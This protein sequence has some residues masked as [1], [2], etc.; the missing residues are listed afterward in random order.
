MDLLTDLLRQCG[1]HRRLLD[2]RQLAPGR[3]LA[4]PCERSIGLHVVTRGRVYVHA[5]GLP[6][7]LELHAGDA[8]VMAR[9]CHHR[10][11]TQ[12]QIDGLPVQTI[13]VDEGAPPEAGAAAGDTTVISGAYQLWHAPVHRLLNELPPWFVVR[14]DSLP[15][16]SPLP[17][18]IGLLEGEAPRREPGAEMVVNG[19]LDA[20]FAWL[21]REWMAR[22]GA[23]RAG[24]ALAVRDPAVREAVRHLHEAPARPWT[25]ESLAQAVGLSRS[26]LAERFRT[27]MGDTPLA[28]LRTLR[29][30][31]AMRLLAESDLTLERVA[32]AVGYQDAFGFSKVFK[33]EVGQAPGEFRRRDAAERQV[34]WRFAAS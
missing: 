14:G 26:V 13:R 25:L 27:A 4:F 34:P 21:L 22:H 10:L 16:L 20:L 8:A 7:P 18:A 23:D 32:Q 15:R 11:A 33:R 1:V 29:M 30:Q 19:L 28:Y 9:G 3:A 24:L 17:L 31:Q 6:E 12:A 2:L 5:E